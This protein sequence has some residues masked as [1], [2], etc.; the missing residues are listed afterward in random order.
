MT[1]DYSMEYDEARGLYVIRSV[2]A[3]VCPSC[4][5]LMSGYDSRRRKA[6]DAAG[7]QRVYL[8]RRFRCPR[9]HELHLQLPD[10]MAPHRHYEAAVIRAVLDGRGQSCPAEDV[11]I[12]RWIEADRPPV[13]C[14]PEDPAALKSDGTDAEEEKP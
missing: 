2:G 9:C 14:A 12:W 7:V 8:L 5:A 6:I 4:G 11:T 3:S 1:H 10:F 13:L